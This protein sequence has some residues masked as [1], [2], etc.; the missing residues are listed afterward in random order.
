MMQDLLFSFF[1]CLLITGAIT[2]TQRFHVTVSGDQ[3]FSGPQ[4]F[5]TISVPRIGGLGIGIAVFL[6]VIIHFSSNQCSTNSM[7]IMIASLPAFTI[8]LA[9][10]ISKNISIRMRLI[11]TAISAFIAIKLLGIQ[12]TSIGLEN[13]NYLMSLSI[14]SIP[15][16]IFAITGLTNAY[17]IIDGFN[18][19]CS[20]VGIITLLGLGYVGYIVNDTTIIYLCPI[21]CGSILGFFLFNY[22]KGNI[23]LG[24]GGAYLIGF[25]CATLSIYIVDQ[26]EQVSP[27]FAIL[28][29]AYPTTETIFSIYRRKLHQNKSLGH[30]DGMHFHTLIYRRLLVH[31]NGAVNANFKTSP[32]LWFINCIAAIPAVLFWNSTSLLIISTLIFVTTYLALYRKITTFKVPKWFRS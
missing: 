5:H 23:F 26:N 2:K 29:N 13:L 16:T 27:W 31:R 32:Y 14:V 9:E 11:V 19:L 22:P 1:A 6:V 3:N 25:W 15:F 7:M 17:N 12:I 10:D 8:G 28:I 20:M 30:P 24:D 4:K 21:M 18:G